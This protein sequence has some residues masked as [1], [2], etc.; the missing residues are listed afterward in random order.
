[1]KDW[2]NLV[3]LIRHHTIIILINKN[4]VLSLLLHFSIPLIILLFASIFNANNICGHTISGDEAQI[5]V[6]KI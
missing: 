4:I 3:R 1:M 2:H 6:E 5:T